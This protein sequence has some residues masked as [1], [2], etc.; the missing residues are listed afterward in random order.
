MKTK[1]IGF[2]VKKPAK[3]CSDNNCPF[4]GNLTVRGRIL[5]GVVTSDK[6]SKTITVS[7][8]R[9]VSVPK[10]ERYETRKSKVKAHNPDCI[11]AKKGDTVRLVETKPLSKTKHFVVIEIIGAQTKE[12]AVKAEL[13]QESLVESTLED[14]KAPAQSDDDHKNKKREEE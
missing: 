12:Q 5:T 8:S 14:K 4:H 10:Y 13:L 6:M 7:W 9:R 2:E 11:G 3:E 1:G